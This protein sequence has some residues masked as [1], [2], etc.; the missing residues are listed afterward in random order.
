NED[1]ER[2]RVEIA[3][4][5]GFSDDLKQ[6]TDLPDQLYKFLK[7]LLSLNPSERPGT[8]EILTAIKT[9]SGLG[10]VEDIGPSFIDSRSSRISPAETPGSTASKL[11]RASGSYV[12][13]GPS[14]LRPSI[15]R[16]PTGSN[17][18]SPLP[19]EVAAADEEGLE[20]SVVLRG[21]KLE[22]ETEQ[23]PSQRPLTPRMIMPPPPTLYGRTT[24]M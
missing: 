10:D 19:P 15:S 17:P 12:R 20:S 22:N 21:R 8:E 9:G 5:A 16:S 11:K 14:K 7:R 6:R 13:P 2:L 3:E 4:W 18:G 23:P 1:V 24:Q